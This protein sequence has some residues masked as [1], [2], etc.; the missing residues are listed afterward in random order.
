MKLIADGG[1]TKA[2]WLLCDG[3][4]VVGRFTTPGINPL[5]LSVSETA[6]AVAEAAAQCG[7]ARVEEIVFYGAGCIGEGSS[8]MRHALSLAFPRARAVTVGSDII[9]AARA[10]C[11]ESEGI[12][13]I[14]GTGANSCLWDGHDIVR[15]TPPMGFI[16]G[17]EGSG[18]VLGKLFLG[19]MYKGLLPG[20][21]K[22][23]FERQYG[24]D[25]YGVYD[26]VYHSKCPNRWLASLAPFV[27]AH[28]GMQ[29]VEALV[30]ENFEAFV[31]RNLLPYQRP[32]LP[33]SFVGSIAHYFRPQ[34]TV[35]LGRHGL[36]IGCVVRCPL[37]CFGTSCRVK[38][39]K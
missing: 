32:D 31:T 34:L 10:T 8:A 3:G 22:E 35:A 38:S 25:L 39:G 30:V 19:A 33:V 13:C 28:I 12:A 7:A 2:D 36:S 16:L 26:R 21:L 4:R 1:S 18:A 14:L 27:A 24:V 20:S 9:G 37:D 6:A 15:Q 29:E 23:E 5:L 11:G 17:D